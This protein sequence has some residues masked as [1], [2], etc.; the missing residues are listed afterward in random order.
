MPYLKMFF[1]RVAALV[2][3]GTSLL[4]AATDVEAHSTYSIGSLNNTHLSINSFEGF[5]AA[6]DALG[7]RDRR[8]FGYHS[9]SEARLLRADEVLG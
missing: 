5:R 7:Y 2:S 6:M 8:N 9:I 3:I 4:C 1:S